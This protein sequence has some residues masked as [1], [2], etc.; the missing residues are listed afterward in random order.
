MIYKTPHRKLNREQ[1]EHHFKPGVNPG[2]T[3]GQAFPAPLETAVGSLF[4][5]TNIFL[6]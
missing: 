5:D 2:A 4:N 1:H 6:I 3:E